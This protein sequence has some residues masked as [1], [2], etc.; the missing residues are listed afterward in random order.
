MTIQGGF[1]VIMEKKTVKILYKNYRGEVA[2]RTIIPKSIGFLST[3][4]HPKEQWILTAF[5]FEKNADRG[6][7][8]ADIQEWNEILE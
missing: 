1:Q 5:D 3:E 4:W 2:Y 8:I 6:F 7:S